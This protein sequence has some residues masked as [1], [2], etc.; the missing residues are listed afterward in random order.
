MPLEPIFSPMIKLVYCFKKRP[1]LTDDEF[2]AY[3]RDVHTL[4]AARIPGLRRLI[5][6]RAIRLS[7]DA[8]PPDF[9]GMAELWFDDA[10]ALQRARTSDAW[11]ESG[12]DERNFI[13]LTSTAY[14]VSEER[15]MIDNPRA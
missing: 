14:F 10:D 4:F 11:R 13:D 5:Q 1:G 9:D 7:G 6:S 3:W 8:R 12:L 2:D 15:T